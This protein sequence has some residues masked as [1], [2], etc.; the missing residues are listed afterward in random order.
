MSVFLSL[1]T[2]TMGDPKGDARCEHEY[3]RVVLPDDA[4]EK[5]IK[6][7]LRDILVDVR[8]GEQQFVV[9]RSSRSRFEKKKEKKK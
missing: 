3:R 7:A 4:D 2:P 6:K 8:K 9:Q 1:S 5:A